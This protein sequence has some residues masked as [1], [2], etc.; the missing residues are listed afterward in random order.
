M[1]DTKPDDEDVPTVEEPGEIEQEPEPE[2]KPE[3]E[4]GIY[5]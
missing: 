3:P 4:P 1:E 2:P 5:F